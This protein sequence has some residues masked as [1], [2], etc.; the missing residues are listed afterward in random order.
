MIILLLNSFQYDDD[1]YDNS[2]KCYNENLCS[3]I[4]YLIL[5]DH[6]QIFKL[7]V[8]NKSPLDLYTHYADSQFV[9]KINE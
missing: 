1:T 8:R 2:A 3:I 9:Q 5:N 7:I 4:T 6:S